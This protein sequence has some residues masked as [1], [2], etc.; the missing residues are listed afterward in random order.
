MSTW[1]C[2]NLTGPWRSYCE[3]KCGDGVITGTE[4]CED[5]SDDGIGCNIGCKTGEVIGWNCTSTGTT[6]AHTCLASC[7]DGY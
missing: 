5:G 2:V 7:G 6:P 1:V 3:E 4:N